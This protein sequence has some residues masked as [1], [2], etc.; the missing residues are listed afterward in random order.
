MWN[1]WDKNQEQRKWTFGQH[2]LCVKE[3]IL[4]GI[5]CVLCFFGYS[6]GFHDCISHH[7]RVHFDQFEW[8][9]TRH[10]VWA[11]GDWGHT[12]ATSRG[13]NVPSSMVATAHSVGGYMR[14]GSGANPCG[15]NW[16]EKEKRETIRR[17][18]KAAQNFGRTKTRYGCCKRRWAEG[19]RETCG[20][21]FSV[22]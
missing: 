20:L 8:A 3:K 11:S 1:W 6:L 18:Q 16:Q 4:Y 14:L 15:R 5:Y 21:K 9:K 19:F 2:K 12:S 10:L 7:I 13:V 22:L 17:G